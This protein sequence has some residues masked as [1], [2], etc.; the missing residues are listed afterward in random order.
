MVQGSGIDAPLN[1][2]GE[3]QAAAF[4]EAYK[5]ISFDKIYTSSLVRTRQTVQ[6]F[7]DLGIP[8]ESLKDLRE[9]SW[10][11]QEGVAFTPETSTEY[12]QICQSW[13]DGDLEAKI[14]GGE[15]P[16]EVAE[17][18]AKGFEYIVSQPN[19]DTVLVC[20]HGR[21]I[22]ILMCW[23]L[24]RPY[25]EMD[26]FKHT[27]TGLYIMNWDGAKYELEIANQVEHLASVAYM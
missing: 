6:S 4:F 11:R 13:I 10:G 3:K 8:V 7:I 2:R 15:S 9:I 17:R 23:M 12:Q 1:D 22:R 20:V 19:E 26:Q 5:H 16:R 25:S 24:N 14:D 21:V 18:L 27:N